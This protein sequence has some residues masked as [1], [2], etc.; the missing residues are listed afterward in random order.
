MMQDADRRCFRAAAAHFTET[1]F[2]I[3]NLKRLRSPS[4]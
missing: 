1:D 2:E 3:A 4:R